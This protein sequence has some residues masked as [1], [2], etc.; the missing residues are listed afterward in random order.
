MAKITYEQCLYEEYLYLLSRNGLAV[1]TDVAALGQ[2]LAELS[3]AVDEVCQGRDMACQEGC[4]HCCVLNVSVLMPEAAVIAAWLAERLSVEELAAMVT[5]LDHQ[6]KFV[7]WMDDGERIHRKI[8]CPFLDKAGSCTIHPV[9]PLVCR[10]VTSL[11]SDLCRQALD[12]SEIE[13]SCSVPSDM[14]RRALVDEAFC[15]FA[16]ALEHC[17][18]ETRSIELSA[19]VL[20]FLQHP[21]LGAKLLRGERIL[22]EQLY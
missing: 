15:S 22:P 18:M 19:G 8:V 21:D 14:L 7:L 13:P 5:R 1:A 2:V 12:S 3:A 11:D 10:G 6:Q 16:R 20:A 9:R 4:P 17:G